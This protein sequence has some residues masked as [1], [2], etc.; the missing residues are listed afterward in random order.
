MNLKI[1]FL[2]TTDYTSNAQIARVQTEYWVKSNI[3]CPNCGYEKLNAFENNRPVA[4]FYCQNCLSEFELK[5]KDNK[6]GN[7]ILDG[8]YSTMLNR[9]A[10]ENNPNFFFLTY[11]KTYKTVN[12]FLIIP[13]HY[14]VPDLIEKRNPLAVTA[15]RAGWIGCNI[16]LNRI[17]SSGRI[18]IIKNS[19]I[20]NKEDVLNKWKETD[21]LKNISV[22]SKGWIIDV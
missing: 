13:K 6:L 12:D 20:I 21:F 14:F 22:K 17:P 5:S 10:A 4:D 18:F 2:N 16:L 3:Y 8:A 1:D 7:K 19:N 9:I 15:R 11:N